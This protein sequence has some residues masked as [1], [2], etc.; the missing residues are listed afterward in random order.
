MN[1]FA[2]ESLYYTQPTV[3]SASEMHPYSSET[4]VTYH[5]K[6]RNACLPSV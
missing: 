1:V 2:F 3:K 6:Q 4:V 5:S